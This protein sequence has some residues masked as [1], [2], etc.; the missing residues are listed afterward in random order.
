[1]DVATPNILYTTYAQLQDDARV[2]VAV[3][4]ALGALPK[5]SELRV[6]MLDLE[7]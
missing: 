6:N 3:P 1:M 5:K 7:H 4:V 2:E